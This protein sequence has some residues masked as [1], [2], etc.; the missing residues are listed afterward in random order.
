MTGNTQTPTDD[1]PLADTMTHSEQKPPAYNPAKYDRPTYDEIQ[2]DADLMAYSKGYLALCIAHYDHIDVD[3]NHIVA[4]EVSHRAKRRAASVGHI[5]LSKPSGSGLMTGVTEPDWDA[6]HDENS[7]AFA[8]SDTYD[9]PKDVSVRLSWGAF[10]AFD[11]AEWQ[12]TLRHELVHII[13]LH[14]TGKAGHSGDFDL[15]AMRVDAKKHC[16]QW[17]DYKYEFS[18][19]E[20]G[21]PAG[22]RHR[23]SK[24]VKFARLSPEGK[25]EWIDSGETFWR[26]EC[27]EDGY[28]N[29]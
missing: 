3:V 24:A 18:C 25:Q 23:E 11:E 19:T 6:L 22:G 17:S 13:Q 20:C 2:T 10:E 29:L 26:T 21:G 5:D 16:P 27:C 9:H 8:R 14:A 28:P 1:D 4:W 15:R 12:D 7:L